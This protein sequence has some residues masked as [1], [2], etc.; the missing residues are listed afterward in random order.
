MRIVITKKFVSDTIAVRFRYS[1]QVEYHVNTVGQSAFFS[2]KKNG[3]REGVD[4]TERSMDVCAKIF[5]P[6]HGRQA[7]GAHN[8]LQ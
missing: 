3:G 7:F 5:S 4:L 1:E 8:F 6:L 2:N